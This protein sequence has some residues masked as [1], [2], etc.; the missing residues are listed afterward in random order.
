MR[1]NAART[2]WR[3]CP[4]VQNPTCS[5]L[6]LFCAHS[7]PHTQA[8]SAASRL[9]HLFSASPS[10]APRILPDCLPPQTGRSSTRCRVPRQ[11]LDHDRGRR[12]TV[13][14]RL[15]RPAT[16]SALPPMPFASFVH[17]CRPF[18]LHFLYACTWRTEKAN[19]L[20]AFLQNT[21]L[22][23]LHMGQT[24][25][26]G[27]P[28]PGY[29]PGD[30]MKVD[31]QS[32]RPDTMVVRGARLWIRGKYL[33]IFLASSCGWWAGVRS[34]GIGALAG[35]RALISMN[36]SWASGRTCQAAG[37]SI[38]SPRQCIIF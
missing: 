38:R 6:H 20:P 36:G 35:A 24:L 34:P 3:P 28:Q 1:R 29:T 11:R 18:F 27:C 5:Q 8:N 23:F 22:E 10:K 12:T 31:E 15:E 21:I 30:C 13:Q 4:P 14:Q 32:A 16:R 26:H 17:F 9:N 7:F 2:I 37:N 19:Q 33:Y 25:D